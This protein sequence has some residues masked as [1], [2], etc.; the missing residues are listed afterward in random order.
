MQGPQA[1]T[2]ATERGLGTS[3]VPTPAKQTNPR[4]CQGQRLPLSLLAANTAVAFWLR[5]IA[6]SSALENFPLLSAFLWYSRRLS[7]LCVGRQLCS[8]VGHTLCLLCLGEE[9]SQQHCQNFTE[10]AS[11]VDVLETKEFSLGEFTLLGVRGS[12]SSTKVAP[13]VKTVSFVALNSGLATEISRTVDDV[14]LKFPQ[15]CSLFYIQKCHGTVRV[16]PSTS[17]LK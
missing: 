5:A 10:Q 13:Q 7:V 9:H 8:T 2:S 17:L 4:D 11:I 12:S 16:L 15:S 6:Y 14:R 1:E 3:C